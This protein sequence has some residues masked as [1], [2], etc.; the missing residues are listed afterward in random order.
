MKKILIGLLWLI[1]VILEILESNSREENNEY[2]TADP[3]TLTVI[4]IAAVVGGTVMSVQAQ[5]Q[6]TSA[7]KATAK[8]N[9]ALAQQK[10]DEERKVGALRTEARREK[11][12]RLLASQRAGYAKAGVT[13]AGTPFTVIT[14]TAKNEALNALLIGREAE[15]AARGF[16]SEK[17][18]FGI[19]ATNIGKAGRLAVGAELIGGVGQVASIGL[20]A[21]ELKKK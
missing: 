14:E 9:A 3:V 7:A 10:A 16:E 13:P 12:R 5:R 18:L 8:Y 21:K 17:S 20:K 6:Q 4:A 2:Y 15:V 11:T 1:L 19:Q